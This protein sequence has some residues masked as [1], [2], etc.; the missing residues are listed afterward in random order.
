[1]KFLLI[2][3]KNRTVYNF[4]GELIGEIK[5]RGYEVVVT[6]PDMTEVDRITDLGVHFVEIPMNKNGTSITGDLKYLW[7]LYRLI[8]QENP[9]AV[10]GYTVKPVVYG[11]IAAHFAGVKNI[12]CLVTGGGYIFAAKTWKARILG[13]LVRFLYRLG[14]R[15]ADHV[16]F[17]NRDDLIEFCKKRL[18]SCKKCSVV[19]GSGVNMEHFMPTPLPEQP[20]F[21]MLS[22]LLKSKGVEEYLEAARIVKSKYPQ[23]IF[24]LLGKYETDMQ[25]AVPQDDVEKLI[26]EGIIERFEET[27]DV[28]PYYGMCSVYILPS[29][30]EGTPR[31]VLEA[32]AMGRPVITTDAPGCRGTVVQGKT[33]FLV[34]VQD[35]QA[36]AEKIS[37]FIDNPKYIAIMGKR[38]RIYAQKNFEVGKVNEKMIRI[39]EL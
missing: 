25:D 28:R 2:A 7:N 37:F 4:R 11:S 39:M 23:A 1:M 16:I 38:S 17:Q 22:R 32:M 19:H 10:L 31:T 8:K 6:G 24:Y 9:D 29:Y 18:V 26:K 27:D 36:I 5:S 14:F 33:G 34:P 12:N 13:V 35:S 30:R 15:F 20:A 3:P 21:F